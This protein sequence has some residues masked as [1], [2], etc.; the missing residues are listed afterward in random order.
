MF[1]DN[2]EQSPSEFYYLEEQRD[3]LLKVKTKH[4]QSMFYSTL[5]R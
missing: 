3:R 2:K 5:T 1:D 4:K